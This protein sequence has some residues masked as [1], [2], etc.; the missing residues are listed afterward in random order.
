MPHGIPGTDIAGWV[1]EDG[2]CICQDCA[3]HVW[4]KSVDA[5]PVF[6]CTEDA[7]T[8][9]CDECGETLIDTF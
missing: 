8:L 7:A 9:T 1:S 5:D 6:A 3:T 2:D 4:I